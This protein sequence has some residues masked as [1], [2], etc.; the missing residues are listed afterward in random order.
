MIRHE[1]KLEFQDY[2]VIMPTEKKCIK[3]NNNKLNILQI[4]DSVQYYIILHA[5]VQR[6]SQHNLKILHHWH[7]QKL[8]NTK[9]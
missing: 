1:M 8:R 9:Q 2:T 6:L 3:S 5:A 4:Y 7:F